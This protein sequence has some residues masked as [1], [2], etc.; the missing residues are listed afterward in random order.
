VSIFLIILLLV[1]NTVISCWN[2]Y[3]AGLGWREATGFMRLVVWSALVMSACGFFQTFAI[4]GAVIA[5]ASHWI[6]PAQLQGMLSLTYLLIIVPVLGSGLIITIHSWRQ[7]MQTR[8]A[9]D[10][11]V[12]G[13]NTFAMGKNAY[14]AASGIPDALAGVGSLFAPDSD[15]SAQSM[16]AKLVIVLI[17]FV[18]GVLAVGGTWLFFRMGRRAAMRQAV[19]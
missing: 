16:I 12:A 10:I 8:S 13:Y 4:V 9:L 3:A 15:D 14:D 11:G 17:L 1:F 19:A 6:T 18:A 7:A 2:A 5:A